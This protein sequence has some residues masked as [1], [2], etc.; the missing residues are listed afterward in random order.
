[1]T[2]APRR[3]RHWVRYVV[4]AVGVLL[5]LGVLAGI[6]AAQIG[7]LMAMGAAFKA[8]GPPPESVTTAIAGEQTW[9][10]TISAVASLVSGKGV[11][12]SNDA[13]GIVTKLHFDSGASVR[14][15]QIR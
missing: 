10:S 7:K 1:M 13:P 3:Q 4:V 14:E 9:E 8:A 5:L 2:P 12:V 11:G 15:G 6:K